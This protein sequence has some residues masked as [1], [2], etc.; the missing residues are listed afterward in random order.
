MLRLDYLGCE[1]WSALRSEVVAAR[2]SR[3]L[4]VVDDVENAIGNDGGKANNGG[5]R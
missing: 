3:S 5:Y 1:A 2:G 4:E